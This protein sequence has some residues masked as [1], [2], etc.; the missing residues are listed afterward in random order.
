MKPLCPLVQKR[1]RLEVSIVETRREGGKVKQKHV[2]SLGSIAGDSPAAL[3]NFWLVCEAK[4]ARLSNR[5]RA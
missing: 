5:T 3:E 2:A 4:F 1:Y